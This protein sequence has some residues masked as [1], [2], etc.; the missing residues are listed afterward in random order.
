MDSRDLEGLSGEAPEAGRR[1]LNHFSDS[2]FKL[3]SISSLSCGCI[4]ERWDKINCFSPISF[5][6][7][8]R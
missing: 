8:F 5:F 2:L 3:E 7:M 4:V 6:W 1:A